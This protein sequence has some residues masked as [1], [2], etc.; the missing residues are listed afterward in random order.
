MKTLREFMDWLEREG[1]HAEIRLCRSD[2]EFLRERTNPADH[3]PH[4]VL[5]LSGRRIVPAL[6]PEPLDVSDRQ[7]IDRSC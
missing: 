6:N 1:R 2:W 4:N 3:H 5:M 7:L